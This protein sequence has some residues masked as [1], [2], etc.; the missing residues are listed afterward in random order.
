MLEDRYEW[1]TAI[2]KVEQHDVLIRGYPLSE[3]IGKLTFADACFLVIRG[4]LPSKGEREVLDAM[5]VSLID[6]GISPSSMIVRMLSSCGTPIQAALAGGVSSIA[7]WHGGA[8]EQLAERLHT[9][10]TDSHNSEDIETALASL[11]A[12]YAELGRRFEGFGHPQHSEGDP[13]VAL[14]RRLAESHNVT[15]P[16]IKT[17]DGLTRQIQ[18]HTGKELR[19]NVN[20]IVAALLLDL[21]FPWQA[22]RGFVITPRTMGLTAH[23]VEERVQGSKWRHAAAEAV[24]Y[25]GEPRRTIK[26]DKGSFHMDGTDTDWREE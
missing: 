7:D 25:T 24:S 3:L 14:L 23:F 2:A 17:L 26:D 9:I 21:G 1:S 10:V 16:H 22:V 12:E 6:H 20:G 19:P 18:E 5:F 4:D 11:V 13:R 15:G 8:G